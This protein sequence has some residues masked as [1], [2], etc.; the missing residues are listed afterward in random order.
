MVALGIPSVVVP[1]PDGGAPI[2]LTVNAG[3][4]VVSEL[5]R[6]TIEYDHAAAQADDAIGMSLRER[7]IVPDLATALGNLALIHQ[8]QGDFAQ[9]EFLYRRALTIREQS[10]GGDHRLVADS[11]DALAETLSSQ[12]KE[13]EALALRKRAEKIR[14]SPS[15]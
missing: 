3:Q 5:A 11:L 15:P 10:L 9:A 2:L 14:A 4:R 1:V 6:G 12:D 7:H 13:V 8:A